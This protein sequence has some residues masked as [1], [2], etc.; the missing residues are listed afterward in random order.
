MR[1]C[2][3]FFFLLIL[4]VLTAQ[5][6]QVLDSGNRTSLRGLSVVND[7]IVWVSGSNGQVGL[8]LNAGTIWQ[9]MTVKGFE[10]TDFRDIE[11]FSSTEAVIMGVGE[12]AYILK[13]ND[14]G[15]TW[16]VVFEDKRPG[17][18][19]D[20]MEFWNEMSGIVIGDPVDGKIFIA[21]TFNGGETWRGLPEANYPKADSGEAMFAASGTNIR[22]LNKSEA[23]FITG[24]FRSRL[25]VRNEKID[26]PFI[27]G[28]QTTGAFSIAVNNKQKMIV[29]GGD[30][31]NDKDTTNNCF[32]KSNSYKVW[33]KPAT[34]P[35][36]FRSC[37]EYI[38]AKKAICCGTSGVDY[39]FDG[40]YNW[41]VISAD[42]YHVVRK[43]KNGK[44]VFLAG[45]NGKIAKLIQ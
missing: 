28:K 15:K 14:A 6:I 9:W 20:A 16:K 44:A 24:G 18:F 42:S 2:L 5:Q 37:V 34:S 4:N 8:S 1:C 17:M 12:P 25:F 22:A 7:F 38:D 13:T 45:M 33:K 29:V 30:Y 32:I 35:H 31:A 23:V 11:A 21:R 41:Q 19:L 26:L 36:G 27:Q 10:K 3:F 39:S 40:G 43:A